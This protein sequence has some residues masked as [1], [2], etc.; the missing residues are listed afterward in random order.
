MRTVVIPL[1]TAVL[2]QPS[3][4]NAQG[5]GRPEL[6]E[7]VTHRAVDIRSEGTRMAG[8]LYRPADAG[9]GPLPA[10]VMSHGRA[11]PRRAWSGTPCGSR[12]TGSWCSR[13]TTGDGAM[14]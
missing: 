12:R 10:I 13:S 14:W 4:T 7:G 11:G 1:L 8:D 6:P 2:L 3:V 9:D 5:Q